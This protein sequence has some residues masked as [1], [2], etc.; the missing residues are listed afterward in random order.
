VA[1]HQVCPQ[2]GQ[3]TIFNRSH[4]EDVLVVK[5]LKLA[6]E[7]A[8]TQRYQQIVNFEDHLLANGTIIIKVV[9]HISKG[10]QRNRLFRRQAEHPWKLSSSDWPTHDRFDE[11]MDIYNVALSKTST[12]SNPWHIVPADNKWFRDLALLRLVVDCLRP[13]HEQWKKDIGEKARTLPPFARPFPDTWA[14][15]PAKAK[16]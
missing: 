1:V 8:I 16:L 7:E 6:S 13:Y 11:Y 9:L 4:Y 2:K 5:L 14:K 15:V 12:K 10:E 3:V